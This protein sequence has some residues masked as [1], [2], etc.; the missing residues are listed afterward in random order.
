MISRIYH[1]NCHSNCTEIHSPIPT[2]Y[3]MFNRNPA[4]TLAASRSI[5]T[6]ISRATAG[7]MR[8]YN[9]SSTNANRCITE[10]SKYWISGR[11]EGF[12]SMLT[13]TL[14]IIHQW[15]AV[16]MDWEQQSST[17][18]N[19]TKR[20][21]STDIRHSRWWRLACWVALVW[22][23]HRGKAASPHGASV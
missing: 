15:K 13:R 20:V 5:R 3:L 2:T 19:W 17:I 6:S 14:V 22:S 9:R 10:R 18:I 12:R 23:W 7:R 8:W 21:H 11:N 4:E 16:Y 1:T